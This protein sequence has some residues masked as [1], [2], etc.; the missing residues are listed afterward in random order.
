MIRRPP[1]STLF[2]YTTLFRSFVGEI[3][4]PRGAVA[5]HHWFPGA[6]PAPL[7]GLSEDAAA[8]FLGRLNGSGISRGSFVAQR[9]T[10][11]IQ[12][13][14]GEHATQFGLASM[15]RFVW[16]LSRSGLS[17]GGHHGHAR[18][19]HLH[20]PGGDPVAGRP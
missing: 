17:L 15:G 8:E 7:I 12:L 13:G 16:L 1:R 10:L 5:Q 14:L 19:R 4:D 6:V 3:P 11:L 18:T 20:V 9:S 2:P